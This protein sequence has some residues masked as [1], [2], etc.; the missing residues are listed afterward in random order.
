MP[1][2]RARPAPTRTLSGWTPSGCTLHSVACC[3][4]ALAALACTTAPP[5]GAGGI[6]VAPNAGAWQGQELTFRV[7]SGQVVDLLLVRQTC[8]ANACTGEAQGPLGATTSAGTVFKLAGNGI[9]LDGRFTS[10]T[11]AAGTYASDAACCKVAGVWAA[12]W[13]PGSGPVTS[14]NRAPDTGG[15]AADATV[16]KGD[17]GPA[18]DTNAAQPGPKDWGGASTGS[19][20]PGPSLPV[21]ATPPPPGASP[22]Q[23]QAVDLLNTLRAH[24]GVLAIKGDS[25]LRQ[26]AQAH[27]A[28][29]GVH[30]S[31]YKAKGVSPHDEDASFGDGFTGTTLPQRLSAAGYSGAP[32]PEIMAFTGSPSGAVQGWLDTVYHRLPLIDPRSSAVG[33]GQSTKGAACEVMDFGAGAPVPATIVVYPWPGQAGVPASWNGL[34]G[35]QP[36]KPPQG[37]PS[38]PII[39]ARFPNTVEVVVHVLLDDKAA[40]VPH[41]WLDAKTDSTLG[42]FDAW[43]KVLYAHKPLAKGSYRVRIEF[44][45]TKGSAQ[46]DVL[47]WRFSVGS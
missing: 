44:K 18:L 1:A 34:E 2:P 12:Q 33:Y 25:A 5:G 21:Q 29:Y 38:G 9:Q 16:G 17:A 3:V 15:T 41:V 37:Y 43:T 23:V 13:V 30:A 45:A 32:G 36:P 40:E 10:A 39:T 47:Q 27:A 46:V 4:G 14:R 7:E 26:A 22:Q 6:A 19:V 31:K 20:H 35:P 28:F 8:K 42:A 11:Q 24:V